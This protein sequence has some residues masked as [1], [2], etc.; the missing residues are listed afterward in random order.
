ME[1][2]KARKEL[3][4]DIQTLV[5]GS[6]LILK[7]VPAT[8]LTKYARV[9]NPDRRRALSDTDPHREVVEFFRTFEIQH[10]IKRLLQEYTG[11]ETLE[12]YVEDTL[13]GDVSCK[14]SNMY[15][16]FKLTNTMRRGARGGAG[17]KEMTVVGILCYG[18]FNKKR[19]QGTDEPHTL[20]LPEIPEETCGELELVVGAPESGVG[21]L[22]TLFAMGDMLQRVK[23]GHPRFEN[24]MC[25][26]V[27]DKMK[28]LLD[29]YKFQRPRGRLE[30]YELAKGKE[31]EN[32]DAEISNDTKSI[33]I[34][35]GR[36]TDVKQLQVQ[37]RQLAP[38]L[39]DMCGKVLP[40]W[41]ARCR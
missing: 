21:Q 27:S 14:Q 40:L 15:L 1:R 41:K 29:R 4:Q 24:I 5:R 38:L 20:V 3:W 39:Y 33:R 6:G 34:F 9:S 23:G 12:Q 35:K 19:G 17:P 7:K 18:A 13:N 11:D 10:Q 26:G 32:M 8:L 37:V 25:M 36:S 22:L 16:A 31:D 30:P 28:R 2:V